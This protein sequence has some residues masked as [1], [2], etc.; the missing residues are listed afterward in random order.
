MRYFNFFILLY[1]IIFPA[2]REP[3]KYI[4]ISINGRLILIVGWMFPNLQF[5]ICFPERVKSD[6]KIFH[7]FYVAPV[8][9]PSLTGYWSFLEMTF[10]VVFYLVQC[11]WILFYFL[12]F[13]RMIWSFPFEVASETLSYYYTSTAARSE[14]LP[15]AA[16]I[17]REHILVVQSYK[18]S[19]VDFF[20]F[21]SSRIFSYTFPCYKMVLETT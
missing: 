18:G 15:T 11:L 4:P 21:S 7:I 12:I 2:P 8:C 17:N 19:Q 3:C 9:N 10:L 6:S 5:I 20:R 16:R 14:K 13:H 1:L